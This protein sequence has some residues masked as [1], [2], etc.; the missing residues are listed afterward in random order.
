MKAS[1][2]S[3]GVLIGAL[4]AASALLGLGSADAQTRTNAFGGL[5]ESS[6]KPIDI[7]SEALTIY[8]DQYALFSGNVKA[9][10]GGTTLRSRE[11]K[12]HFVGNADGKGAAE[13]AK[14]PAAGASPTSPVQREGESASAPA[15]APATQP[16]PRT[17]QPA[18]PAAQ[19]PASTAKP[20]AP[21]EQSAAKAPSEG[22]KAASKDN[23]QGTIDEPMDIQSDLL[24]VHD[25]EK[26]AHFKGNVRV[27]QGDTRLSSE[28]LKVNYSG[29]DSLAATSQPNSGS[30][31]Q[32]TKIEA[33][34][35]VRA[36]LAPKGA[37]PAKTPAK[38]KPE[39]APPPALTASGGETGAGAPAT[40]ARDV[41]ATAPAASGEGAPASAPGRVE[42]VEK[43]EPTTEV[44]DAAP[45][46]KK[47]KQISELEATGGV[48]ITS[49]NDETATSDWAVYN[50]AS[51]LVT[52]G[53]N[54]VLTQKDTVLK[55]DR[56][57][58]DLKSGESRFENTGTTADGGGR[59]IR[60]LFMPKDE[61]GKPEKRKNKNKTGG[62]GD[63][64]AGFPQM[65]PASGA[66]VDDTEPLPIVPEYR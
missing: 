9:E 49:E 26:Y 23:A 63:N 40:V 16:A 44:A 55:G 12:V 51:D 54:V 27:V 50:L 57:V 15:A 60:A 62:P 28:E 10:Q 14:Q 21:T 30:P 36:H 25:K 19:P 2:I 7:Q 48:V 42:T 65:P 39:A 53:G 41:P 1:L 47:N 61:G 5:S 58:I 11:L 3:S 22:Q 13:P 4:A 59:R 24:L 38:P 8:T 33:F 35:D 31:T 64:A 43:T 34:G 17:G 45:T 46:T 20:V 52:I 18:T 37:K 56:L 66:A 29:G 32:I 6:D